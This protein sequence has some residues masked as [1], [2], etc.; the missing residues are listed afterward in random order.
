[1][2]AVIQLTGN[3][4]ITTFLIMI[5]MNIRYSAVAGISQALSKAEE[6]IGAMVN[7]QLFWLSCAGL[8]ETIELVMAVDM[9]NANTN[10]RTLTS[11]TLFI[12]KL[13]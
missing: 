9:F 8:S 10:S 3:M 1:M 2:L 13:K 11:I 5:R 4:F 6:A 12:C 7:S